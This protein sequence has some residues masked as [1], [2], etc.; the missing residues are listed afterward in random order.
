M[1]NLGAQQAATQ[2]CAISRGK[3]GFPLEMHNFLGEATQPTAK[4]SL[5][6]QPVR[7]M[8]QAVIDRLPLCK[9]RLKLVNLT[10]QGKL[11]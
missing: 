10:K 7:G 2:D 8:D 3:V 9:K 6:E 11:L 4:P 1:H 5:G